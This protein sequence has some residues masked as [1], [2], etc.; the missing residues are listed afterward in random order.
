M[1]YTIRHSIREGLSLIGFKYAVNAAHF[2]GEGVL[3][4][5]IPYHVR[6]YTTHHLHATGERVSDAMYGCM[7]EIIA[8]TLL[9]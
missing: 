8:A 3:E 4:E 9:V 1:S 6:G 5:L 2:I 7:Q